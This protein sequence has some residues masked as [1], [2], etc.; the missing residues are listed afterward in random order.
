MPRK[1]YTIEQIISKLQEAV[2]KL[3][4]YQRKLVWK[5]KFIEIYFGRN[6]C[7]YYSSLTATRMEGMENMENIDIFT[8]TYGTG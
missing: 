6:N 5:L 8:P 7:H 3:E 4:I 1:S 2:E